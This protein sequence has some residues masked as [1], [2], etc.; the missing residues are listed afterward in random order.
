MLRCCP[1]FPPEPDPAAF[2]VVLELLLEY[3]ELFVAD[4]A[5]RR[6][7]CD[8]CWTSARRLLF[9]VGEMSA[10]AIADLLE[11]WRIPDR[12]TCATEQTLNEV[13]HC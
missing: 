1:G 3:D 7:C 6:C 2:V 12:I 10:I 11:I 9:V 4:A 5:A 13:R 8:S